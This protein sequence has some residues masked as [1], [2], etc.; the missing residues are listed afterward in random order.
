MRTQRLVLVVALSLLVYG[1]YGQARV[2]DVPLE[3]IVFEY[4]GKDWD[5]IDDVKKYTKGMEERFEA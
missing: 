5:N 4:V 3:N 2:D 1:L